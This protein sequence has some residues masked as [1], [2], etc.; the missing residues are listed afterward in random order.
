MS[1]IIDLFNHPSTPYQVFEEEMLLS[2]NEDNI[3]LFR[4]TVVTTGLGNYETNCKLQINVENKI[5]KMHI[6]GT[7]KNL[8]EERLRKSF[9]LIFSDTFIKNVHRITRTST[10]NEAMTILLPFFQYVLFV[11]CLSKHQLRIE[12]FVKPSI[13][14]I[15]E[16][17]INYAIYADEIRLLEFSK[18]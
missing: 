12:P 11:S 2:H 14:K 4:D 1:L 15:R 18:N 5:C 8:S 16:G 3:P 17:S 7:R 6:I 10:P 9:I 13:Y